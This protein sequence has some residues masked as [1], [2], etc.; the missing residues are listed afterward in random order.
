[1][2][3]LFSRHVQ[4]GLWGPPNLFFFLV[5]VTQ[6]EYAAF[7]MI[8]YKI[9]P[10]TIWNTYLHNGRSGTEQYVYKYGCK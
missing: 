3:F 1:M 7:T 4:T 10:V 6:T 5:F 8:S 2:D 9:V